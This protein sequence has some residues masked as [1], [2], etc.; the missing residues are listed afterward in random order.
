MV[1]TSRMADMTPNKAPT[2]GRGW[3]IGFVLIEA[4]ILGFIVY[5]V[6]APR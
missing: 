6:L 1:L 5:H 3:I 2:V 4:V